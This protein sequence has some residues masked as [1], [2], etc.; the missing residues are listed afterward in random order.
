MKRKIALTAALFA[1]LLPG[2]VTMPLT[3]QEFREAVPKARSAE[4]ETFE[5]NRPFREVAATFRGRADKCLAITIRT[6]SSTAQSY[7]DYTTTY[8]PTVVVA[9]DRAELH[10]QRHLSNTITVSP[11]PEG[12]YYLMVVDAFPAGRNKTKVVMYRPAWAFDVLIRAVKGWASGE[13]LGCPDLTK[14]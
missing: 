11:E 10:L 13:T 6:R 1:T 2:C 14:I 5:V 3:A 7:Q 12:G 4:M 9:S 8:K